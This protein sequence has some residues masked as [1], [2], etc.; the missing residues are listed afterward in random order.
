MKPSDDMRTDKTYIT[1]AVDI[2]I[3][4]GILALMVAW[5]FQILKPFITPVVWGIIIAVAIYPVFQK[6]NTK[7]GD[8]R[9]LASGI[10]T[11]IGLLLI[12]LPSIELAV[13]GIDG[14]Q[15]ISE[16][17]SGVEFKVPPP[18]E[19]I[20]DWPVIGKS[21]EKMWQQTSVNLQATLIKFAPQAKAFAGW[22]LKKGIGSGIGLLMFA[23]SI[24]IAGILMATADSGGQMAK[25]LFVRLAGERGTEFAEISVKTIRG[26]VKGVLGVAVIQG[27]LAGIGYIVAGIP[28]AGVWA[29][30]SLFFAVIQIGVAPVI[31]PVIIYAFYKLSTLTAVLLTIWL[32]MV[33][34]V[35]G[36]LKAILLGRGAAVPMLVIF[37][38]SIGGFISMGFL[39]L[40]IGAVVL[41]LAYKLF[42]AWLNEDKQQNELPENT[43]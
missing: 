8:R 36:P 27:L 37:L 5:C 24:I 19:G 20:A 40:F 41:S 22:L 35:D 32:V 4:L 31:I 42:E 38:G 28:G 7:L 18:P 13:S 10:L 12:I 23:V 34:I 29:F 6:L 15:A 11:I 25:N 30:L 17:L 2:A 43:A 21:V 39:G 26:V 1:H 16:K 33:T 14:V 9:K 3:R